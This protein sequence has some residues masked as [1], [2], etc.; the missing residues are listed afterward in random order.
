MKIEPTRRFKK[1]YKYYSK[2][3]YPMDKI[4]YCLQ[5]IQTNDQIFLHKH[6][7]HKLFA[8]FREMHI[9]RQYNDDWLLIYNFDV[10]A[11]ELILVLIDLG[12]HSKLN[13]LV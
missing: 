12:T 4:S 3:H 10:N 8:N 1:S 9:D 7:D 13:R 5:A 11:K 6:K 2:K